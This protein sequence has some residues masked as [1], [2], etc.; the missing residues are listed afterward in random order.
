MSVS[1]TFSSAN[2]TWGIIDPNPL[3]YSILCEP[4]LTSELERLSAATSIGTTDCITLQPCLN[5]AKSNQ[6]RYVVQDWELP[7]GKWQ[8]TAVFDGMGSHKTSFCNIHHMRCPGHGGETTVNYVAE[9]LS[10]LIQT[11]LG[12]ALI[13]A[14]GNALAPAIVSDILVRTIADF[15]EAILRD[16][17]DLF[18]GGVEEIHALSTD[19]ISAIINDL[20]SGGANHTKVMRSMQG[21]TVL[22]SLVD[23]VGE[24][25]WVAS[26]G[27]CQAGQPRILSTDFWM[28]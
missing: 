20:E 9:A 15:D 24:N 4:A 7:G 25:L 8:F 19:N 26:L 6:D 11:V 1:D 22:V 16:F 5:P 28:I 17:L 23:P 13:N 27:D 12:S 10:P 3:C 14:A 21:S 18:P 2:S